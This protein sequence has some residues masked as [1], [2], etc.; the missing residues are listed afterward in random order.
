MPRC[1]FTSHRLYVDATLAP[2]A[3]IDLDPA[4]ANYLR[5]V[6]RLPDGAEILVFNGRDGEW[7]AHFAA[8]NRK[9]VA[10]IARDLVRPQTPGLDLHYLFAPL[11]HA[12]L[13][14]MIQKAVEMGAGVLRPVL[15]RRTQAERING[16]RMRANAIE[17]AEQCGILS[18]PEIAPVIRLDSLSASWDEARLLIFCDEDAPVQDPFEALRPL[19]AAGAPRPLAVLIGPEGG[20]DPAERD[21]LMALPQILRLS[22]GPRILRADTAA[23]AA[24]AVIQAS[25]GDWRVR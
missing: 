19:A 2:D 9:S 1:D 4:Q 18:I 5:N 7:R 25:L 13:D 11:K 6:L 16:D 12:R 20:F 23:V 14:Y 15:T 24:L 8:A 21:A 3:R 10:L 17:A 22:L